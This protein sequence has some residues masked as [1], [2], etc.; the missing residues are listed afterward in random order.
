MM[1]LPLS[2]SI[3]S[4]SKKLLTPTLSMPASGSSRIR[5]RPRQHHTLK[6]ASGKAADA[7]IGFF[8][9]AAILHGGEC[10]LAVFRCAT[11][12]AGD[13]P[14]DSHQNDVQGGGGEGAVK[15]FSLR[16]IAKA[17]VFQPFMLGNVVDGDL[18]FLDVQKPHDQLDQGGFPRA[19]GA[20]DG[21]KHAI[22][23]LQVD[24][25][26]DAFA[27]DPELQ[28]LDMRLSGSKCQ[29]H[30]F[31]VLQDQFGDRG[32]VQRCPDGVQSA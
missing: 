20:D 19:I 23:D 1:V 7:V 28:V 30:G 17:A 16:Q 4:S 29:L 22:G 25:F 13:A 2:F 24:I 21:G 8:K 5:Y 11:A 14:G 32:Y 6:L 12:S 27:G 3:L 10:F 31:P 18:A 9:D 26:Q 15:L